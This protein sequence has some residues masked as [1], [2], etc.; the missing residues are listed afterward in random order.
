MAG[1][2]AGALFSSLSAALSSGAGVAAECRE[3]DGACAGDWLLL[4][5]A[6]RRQQQWIIQI[7]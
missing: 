1:A 4:Q 7:Q 2:G 3:W 5:G 6:A